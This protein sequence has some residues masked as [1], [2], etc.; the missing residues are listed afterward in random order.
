MTSIFPSRVAPAKDASDFQMQHAS[1]K[2]QRYK[3]LVGM[4]HSLG[5]KGNIKVTTNTLT[6]TPGLIK[7][8]LQRQDWHFFL[9]N[10]FKFILYFAFF[11]IYYNQKVKKVIEFRFQAKTGDLFHY[12][13]SSNTLICYIF[14]RNEIFLAVQCTSFF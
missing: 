12:P 8:S 5:Q 7:T 4:C 3:T 14:G 13:H 2:P 10:Q 6:A 9:Q 1:L 11:D